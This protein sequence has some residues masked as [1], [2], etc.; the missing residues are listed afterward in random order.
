MS[1]TKAFEKEFITR[2]Q[3]IIKQADSID[4]SVTLLLNCTL[5]LVCLPIERSQN[6][7]GDSVAIYNTL[8]S[9]LA[10][11]LD[12]LHVIISE[13]VSPTPPKQ[14][15]KCL[16]NGIAH[17]VMDA[18]NEKGSITGVTIQGSTTHRSIS[19]SCSFHFSKEQLKK[20]ALF[21]SSEYLKIS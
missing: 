15:L 1:Y 3:S 8:I 21:M 16:R 2:T 19:Y 20:Y 5:A 13:T 12:A 4:Y 7:T 14:K 10:D 9:K 18:I 6:V 17:I 11:K